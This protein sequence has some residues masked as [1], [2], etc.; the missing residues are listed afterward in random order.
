MPTV[1]NEEK[2]NQVLEIL[3]H[4]KLQLSPADLDKLSTDNDI[5]VSNYLDNLLTDH[6][7]HLYSLRSNNKEWNKVAALFLQL[8]SLYFLGH[9]S[10]KAWNTIWPLL[11]KDD[12]IAVITNP[13]GLPLEIAFDNANYQALAQLDIIYKQL[14]MDSP[15]YKFLVH[16]QFRECLLN[17]KITS[18]ND[19]QCIDLLLSI[20]T[21]YAD[22][23]NNDTENYFT[24]RQL[25]YHRRGIFIDEGNTSLFELFLEVSLELIDK[26]DINTFNRIYSYLINNGIT[27]DELISFNNHIK[28][29]LK[30]MSADNELNTDDKFYAKVL[31]KLPKAENHIRQKQ[32]IAVAQEKLV[33]EQQEQESATALKQQALDK[34]EEQPINEEQKEITAPTINSSDFN[35]DWQPIITAAMEAAIKGLGS[36]LAGKNRFDLGKNSKHDELNLLKNYFIEILAP[37]KDNKLDNNLIKTN[38]NKFWDLAAE[39]R[40]SKLHLFKATYSNTHSARAFNEHIM[41]SGQNELIA[42]MQSIMTDKPKPDVTQ[43]YVKSSFNK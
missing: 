25:A 11:N 42:Y 1:Q 32:L 30:K 6:A 19:K 12:Q 9:L 43:Q 20:C 10:D 38:L 8:I 40:G 36:R 34:K 13:D 7:T 28:D 5:V 23:I 24:N 37:S 18:E 27:L 14:L 26:K 17:S 16:R 3:T 35:P 22:I 21:N 15:Q 39:P 2:R 41:K 29:T 4:F 31:E 33:R